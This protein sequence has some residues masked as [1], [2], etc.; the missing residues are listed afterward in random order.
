MTGKKP[1]LIYVLVYSDAF[2]VYQIRVFQTPQAAEDAFK[3]LCKRENLVEVLPRQ[4][5][6]QDEDAD[7]E[8]Q[9]SAELFSQWAR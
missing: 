3:A 6:Q 5:R 1:V 4:A 9:K 2:T 8:D 7:V